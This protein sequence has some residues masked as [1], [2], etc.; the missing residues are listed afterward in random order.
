M[1]ACDIWMWLWLVPSALL[2]FPQQTVTEKLIRAY[3]ETEAAI[4]VINKTQL[5]R[6]HLAAN[7]RA[8]HLRTS[9]H[10]MYQML[11]PG[12]RGDGP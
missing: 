3:M 4:T 7:G 9:Q 2:S 10:T 8:S 11:N 12:I 5:P 6:L 1:D